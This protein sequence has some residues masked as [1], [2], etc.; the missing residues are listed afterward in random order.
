MSLLWR[1]GLVSAAGA[2]VV[3]SRM[4]GDLVDRRLKGREI[5]LLAMKAGGNRQMGGDGRYQGQATPSGGIPSPRSLMATT[6]PSSSHT[7]A[8]CQ[9]VWLAAAMRAR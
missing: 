6:A 8:A 4:R 1:V 9:P 7:S 2:G 3:G 5:A